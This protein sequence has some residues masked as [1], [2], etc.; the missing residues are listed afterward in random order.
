VLIDFLTN[1]GPAY[2]PEKSGELNIDGFSVAFDTKRDGGQLPQPD[3]YI[4]VIQYGPK[5]YAWYARQGTG[6]GWSKVLDPSSPVYIG[7]QVNFG[8]SVTNN[9]FTRSP[10]V[11]A[12]FRFPRTL[13]VGEGVRTRISAYDLDTDMVAI[14]PMD[15]LTTSVID[16][17]G[18][19]AFST[20]IIPEFSFFVAAPS[21]LTI[22][23]VL[24]EAYGHRRT[25]IPRS[26]VTGRPYVRE[27]KL[28]LGWRSSWIRLA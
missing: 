10:H 12:E 9:N 22:L 5:V 8:V 13:F 28:G 2:N 11:L 14:W 18:D 27:E 7:V 17:Y 19:V 20:Q 1:T 15:A 16:L 4:F 25:A 3:D 6:S 26:R 23:L 21:S 24:L